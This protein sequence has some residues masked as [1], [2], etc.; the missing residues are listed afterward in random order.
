MIDT[1]NETTT[2]KACGRPVVQGPGGHRKRVYCNAACK[3]RD[4]RRQQSEKRQVQET[5]TAQKQVDALQA[6]IRELES[7]LTA[8]QDVNERFR[9]DTRVRAFAPWLEKRAQY[10]AASSFGQRFL[11]DRGERLLPP[12][13]S[14]SNYERI[15]RYTLKYSEE[16]LEMFREAWREMLKTQF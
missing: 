14:R 2:C 7:R 5:D 13:A 10:Y 16:D 3:M 4:R 8:I 1:V 12:S 15:M 9:N 6:R 11:A